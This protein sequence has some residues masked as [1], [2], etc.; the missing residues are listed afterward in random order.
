MIQ[1]QKVLR[2]SSKRQNHRALNRKNLSD[3]DPAL[4]VPG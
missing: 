4:E 2:I 1:L 3:E